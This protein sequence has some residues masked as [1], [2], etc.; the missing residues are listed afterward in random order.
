MVNLVENCISDIARHPDSARGEVT[1][2]EQTLLCCSTS[3]DTEI[4]QARKILHMES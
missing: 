1:A 3:G 2:C 4:S